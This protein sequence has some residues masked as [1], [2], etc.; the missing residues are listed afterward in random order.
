MKAIGAHG[1]VP[2]PGQARLMRM[3]IKG[4]EEDQGIRAERMMWK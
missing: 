3:N 4:I 1:Q 2:A